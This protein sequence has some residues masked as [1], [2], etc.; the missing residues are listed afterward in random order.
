ML[1]RASSTLARLIQGSSAPA[2]SSRQ[3]KMFAEKEAG[4]GTA[5][6]WAR[7]SDGE[8]YQLT[9]AAVEPEMAWYRPNANNLVGVGTFVDFS[10]AIRTSANI[11]KSGGTLF[12]IGVGTWELE[13]GLG[14]VSGWG[15]TYGT[16]EWR[17]NPNTAIS[18]S[19]QLIN[20]AMSTTGTDV[21]P[22]QKALSYLTVASGTTTVGLRC[23]AF[24]AANPAYTLEQT[25]AKI[26]RISA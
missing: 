22:Q 23:M 15:A 16:F 3:V 14:A 1:R 24:G 17:I 13:A 5:Q 19:V 12:V 9:P 18:G 26:R 6:L 11:S 7:T 2:A 21:I 10:T 8:I 25:Y 4:T 20:M